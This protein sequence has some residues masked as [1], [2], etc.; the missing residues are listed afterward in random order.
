[1]TRLIF[2]AFSRWTSML[3]LIVM[4]A[5]PAFGRVT[6]IDDRGTELALSK[7]AQRIISLAPS[8]TELLFAA[9]AGRRIVGTVDY[10]D[11][12]AAARAI[13]RI[14]NYGELNLEA[15]LELRPDLIVAWGSGSPAAQLQRLRQLGIPVYMSEPRR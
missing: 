12:P 6:A 9:G 10:S 1:M 5:A 13:P 3:L 15:L 7:P 14:G 2:S 4:G 8:I 11:Y